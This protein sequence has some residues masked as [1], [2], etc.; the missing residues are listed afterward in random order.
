M[1]EK[2]KI[3]RS[4]KLFLF[5]LFLCIAGVAYYVYLFVDTTITKR[6]ISNDQKQVIQRE[7]E[8]AAF[9]D[10]PGFDKLQLVEELERTNYQMPRSDH[11][12]AVIE[13]FDAVLNVD[14]AETRNIILSDFK[15]SL[16]EISLRGYV[17]NLR[18]LY[19]SPDPEKNP[20][21][22]ERFERLGFLEDISIRTYQKADDNI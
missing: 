14:V 22:I 12:Q 4:K 9:S 2:I 11:I 1:A 8:I 10:I 20:S 7:S 21:L 19:N 13:I 3:P 16:N 17:S 6:L 5:L 18:V 15:I